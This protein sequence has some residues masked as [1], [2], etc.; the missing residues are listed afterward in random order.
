LTTTAVAAK[1]QFAIQ[2]ESDDLVDELLCP[3]RPNASTKFTPRIVEFKFPP[4]TKMPSNVK[5]YDGTGD[6]D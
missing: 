6:P 3:Y 2:T 5:M 1:P 4:N